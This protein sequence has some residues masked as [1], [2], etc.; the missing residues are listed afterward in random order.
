MSKSAIARRN[1]SGLNHEVNLRM[2]KP[3]AVK[4]KP[5]QRRVSIVLFVW[6]SVTLALLGTAVITNLTLRAKLTQYQMNIESIKKQIEDEKKLAGKVELEIAQ[7]K[8][9]NRILKIATEEIGMVKPSEVH[10]LEETSS[11]GID[12]AKID[13]GLNG[14]GEIRNVDVLA[15]IHRYEPNPGFYKFFES[16]LIFMFP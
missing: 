15:N 3:S 2:V 8:S 12:V 6:F 9:P 4:R 14:Y 11:D 7:L 16:T 5:G 1:R 13:A 10:Y